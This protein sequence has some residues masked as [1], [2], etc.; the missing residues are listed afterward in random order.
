M[1]IHQSDVADSPSSSQILSE[2][3]CR[4]SASDAPS[5]ANIASHRNPGDA[6]SEWDH[7]ATVPACT[8]MI[9]LGGKQGDPQHVHLLGR[10]E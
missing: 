8:V 2:K 10:S 4:L 9:D 5:S 3:V 6:W 7:E 1:A